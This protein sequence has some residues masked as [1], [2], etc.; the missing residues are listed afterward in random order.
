MWG[1]SKK[2]RNSA[3]VKEDKGINH[4]NIKKNTYI[5]KRKDRNTVKKSLNKYVLF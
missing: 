3:A 2:A 4:A 5:N 1:S